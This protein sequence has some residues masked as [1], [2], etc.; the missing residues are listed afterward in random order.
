M[1]RAGANKPPVPPLDVA[2]SGVRLEAHLAG[3]ELRAELDAAAVSRATLREIVPGLNP[4]QPV[5]I[6][7]SAAGPLDA[8]ELDARLQSNEARATLH[9][10]ASRHGAAT[11]LRARLAASAIDLA[12]FSTR[13][14]ATRLAFDASGD[15]DA[16]ASGLRGSYRLHGTASRVARRPVPELTLR[17]QFEVPKARPAH[18]HGWRSTSP[19]PRRR[20]S[21]K[22]RT[23]PRSARACMP[24]PSW[25][26]RDVCA[27]S[28]A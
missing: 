11:E 12:Q 18:T 24:R 3:D 15:L 19:A 17:G 13:A 14:P 21:M 8:L 22:S 16:G 26:A 25:I 20:S 23:V 9:V 27:R 10:Q 28:P 7:V 2:G 4:K 5:G 1:K 6:S